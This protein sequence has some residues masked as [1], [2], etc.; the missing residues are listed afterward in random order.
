MQPQSVHRLEGVVEIWLNNEGSSK[1][2]KLENFT[3]ARI[4]HY[5]L[6]TGVSLREDFTVKINDPFFHC[7]YNNLIVPRFKARTVEI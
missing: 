3:T 4:N 6:P 1:N 5:L 7:C 2:A